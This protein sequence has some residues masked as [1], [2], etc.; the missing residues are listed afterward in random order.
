MAAEYVTEWLEE[1]LPE[2]NVEYLGPDDD[3]THLWNV[4]VL[5]TGHELRVGVPDQVVD[6]EG[7]LAERLMETETQGWLDQAGERDLW[8]LVGPGDTA[9]RSVSWEGGFASAG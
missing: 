5:G 1:R 7:L 9:L 4:E 6:D 2:T 8:V 3:E